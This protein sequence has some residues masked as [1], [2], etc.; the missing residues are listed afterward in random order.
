MDNDCSTVHA[1]HSGE[2]V[3]AFA[4]H[5]AVQLSGSKVISNDNVHDRGS[6]RADLLQTGISSMLRRAALPA[7]VA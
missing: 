7:R 6:C 3:A 4:N 2:T 5:A 1:V